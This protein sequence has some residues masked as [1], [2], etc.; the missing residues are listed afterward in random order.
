[1]KKVELKIKVKDL[2]KQL[3]KKYTH[4]INQSGDEMTIVIKNGKDLYSF[5]YGKTIITNDNVW[6]IWFVNNKAW[7]SVKIDKDY[8]VAELNLLIKSIQ[9]MLNGE[10]IIDGIVLQKYKDANTKPIEIPYYQATMRIEAAIDFQIAMGYFAKIN[11]YYLDKDLGYIFVIDNYENNKKK[12]CI[13]DDTCLVSIHKDFDI[14][15]IKAI[16]HNFEDLNDAHIMIQSLDYAQFQK[17]RDRSSHSPSYDLIE[18]WGKK[19]N[20][21]LK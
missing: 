21:I 12:G 13:Y 8:S 7:H 11:Q 6:S 17:I 2:V 10:E 14:N 3:K 16:M 1:M 19:L 20:N 18:K 5:D 4:K 9:N 15:D